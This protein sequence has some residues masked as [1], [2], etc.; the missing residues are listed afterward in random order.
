MFRFSVI[1][2]S[3]ALIFSACDDDGGTEGCTAD[4]C[5]AWE[6]CGTDGVCQLADNRC[7]LATDCP[8]LNMTCNETTHTCE[9]LAECVLSEDCLDPELPVCDNG[10]CIAAAITCNEEKTPSEIT[11]TEDSCGD[12]G[13][14]IDSSDCA[15]NQRCENIAVDG[16]EFARACCVEGLRGCMAD[17]EVCVDEFDCESGLC[18]NR[19]EGTLYCTS[20]CTDSA[21]CE[22]PIEECYD[23]VFMQVCVEPME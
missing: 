18:M 10:T 4:S 22:S 7:V 16:E 20:Q 5:A 2:F 11:L 12:M 3:A 17:G 8:G 14:C 19:N 13:D 15:E 9:A 23:M 1:I 21:Q 6:V